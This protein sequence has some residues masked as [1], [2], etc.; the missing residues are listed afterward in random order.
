MYFCQQHCH[1]DDVRARLRARALLHPSASNF[2]AI[3]RGIDRSSRC[4]IK[5]TSRNTER[6]APRCVYSGAIESTSAPI[7][8]TRVNRAT[9][10]TRD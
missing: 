1:A 5:Y 8:N 10:D 3:P 7:S 9:L 4:C 2:D 6:A